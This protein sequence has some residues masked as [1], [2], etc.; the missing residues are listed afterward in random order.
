MFR[1]IMPTSQLATVFLLC[2][3][4]Q[5]IQVSRFL[6]I[7]FSKFVLIYFYAR[8]NLMVQDGLNAENYCN[9]AALKIKAFFI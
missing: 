1:H 6:L 9:F 5:F 2:I 8:I 3:L 4:H 7:L